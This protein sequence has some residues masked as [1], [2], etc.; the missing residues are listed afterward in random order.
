MKG[1]LKSQTSW[2]QLI[3]LI[4]SFI[5]NNNNDNKLMIKL[6]MIKI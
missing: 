2:A 4:K 5:Y 3:R 1:N 6:A